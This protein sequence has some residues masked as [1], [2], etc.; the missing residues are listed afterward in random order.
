MA[1]TR[2]KLK[3]TP[4]FGDSAPPLFATDPMLILGDNL[5]TLPIWVRDESVDLVYLDPPFNSNATYNM[6]FKHVDGTP[7]AAQIQAFTDTWEW[8]E[9]A[10]AGYDRA[11]RNGGDVAR[12]MH[13]FWG[14]LDGPCDMLAY[15]SMMAPRLVELHRVLKADGSIFLHCDP[16]ASHYL[17]L[18]MDAVFGPPRFQNE[19]IWFYNGGGSSPRRWSRKH[20]TIFWYSKGESWTFNLDDVRTPYSDELLA[21]PKSSYK[22]HHYGNKANPRA[23]TDGWDLNPKG[24]RPDDVIEMPII[25]PAARERLGYPTQKPLDLLEIFIRAASNP[26]DTILD[27]FAGCGTAIDAA[28]RLGRRWIGIDISRRATD[29]I[30]N[31]LSDQH[32]GITWTLRIFP[33]TIEEANRLAETDRHAF[34]EWA[35]YRIGA[36]PTGKGADRGID[37]TIDG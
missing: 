28:Q 13:S 18:L 4:Y 9:A 23:V 5:E 37:G 21:R 1:P 36:A 6:L 11:L 27:P 25:N 15:L 14:L 26:G 35:C 2:R 7:A 10:A 34:Q 30:E 22:H 33:P 31:R 16:T 29:V 24:K 12:V 8:N 32:P 17:K 19:L 3:P 20:D